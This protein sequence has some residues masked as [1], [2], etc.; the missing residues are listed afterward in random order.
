MASSATEPD[1]SSASSSAGD[2]VPDLHP[3]DDQ[4]TETSE[5]TPTETAIGPASTAHT[6]AGPPPN[7]R[8]C[9]VCLVDE[10]EATL[11]TDWATPC[12]CSL[13]GHQ[14]CLL[15]WI[16]DLEAQA[17]DVKCPVC[18]SPVLVVERY[19]PAL[20]L[21][22]YLNGKFSRWS[23]RILLGFI[24]Y[25]A[26]VSGSWYG[27][28]AISWFAGPEAAKAFL[29][30]KGKDVQFFHLIRLPFSKRNLVRFSILPFVAPALV[31]NRMNVG[32]VI[33]LPISIVYAA[34]FNHTPDNGTWPPSPNR[35]MTLY[36]VLKSTY[37]H[38]HKVVSNSLEKAWTAKARA[39]SVEHGFQEAHDFAPPPE[40]AP[41]MNILDLEIDIQIGE[42]D[43]D[44][45]RNNDNG[46]RIRA[47]D[48]DGRSSVNFI[49]GALLWPGVSYGVGELMRKLLP[50]RFVSRPPDGPP[51][52]L[53]QERWGRSLIGGC[54]FVVLKD[55]FFL[56][57]KYKR[58]MNRP[59]RRIKN[60]DRRH[61]RD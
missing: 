40:P 35:V 51:T 38:I 31:I 25:G 8:R 52:G 20:Q 30:V 6:G 33:T 50:A 58:I 3:S 55:V 27:V 45:V 47:A 60:S 41:A 22:N 9:F 5:S 54:L 17:K 39:V 26:V 61:F 46:Q 32:D 53:L 1:S 36:P 34:L 16:T 56:Y 4:K 14:E 18:K 11:P 44:D 21:S 19:D 24:A 49:T 42:V 10:P 2:T 48:A 29:D 23:P 13:E 7:T 28:Q 43:N 15:A 59:Y 37:F 57:V 12:G